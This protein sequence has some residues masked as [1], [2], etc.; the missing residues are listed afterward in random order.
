MPE[1]IIN[2]NTREGIKVPRLFA[3]DFNWHFPTEMA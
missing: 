3:V 2:T 1:N